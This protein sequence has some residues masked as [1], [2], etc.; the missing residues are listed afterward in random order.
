MK[1]FTNSL[2]FFLV[3]LL[4]ISCSNDD[5]RNNVSTD[6]EEI[7]E[8]VDIPSINLIA[9]YPFNGNVNDESSNENNGTNF[10]ASLTTDRFGNENAAFQ[11]DG[12]DDY[13]EIIPVSDVTAIGDFTFSVWTYLESWENQMGF[14]ELDRQ[15][16]FNGH[17]HSSSVTSDFFRPGFNVEFGY[18]NLQEE[19]LQNS[20]VYTLEDLP[21]NY[22]LTYK[23]LPLSGKWR[24]I[25]W[26]R[27]GTQDFSYIDGE[28]FEQTYP[29]KINKSTKLNMQHS[30]YIGTF[31]GNNTNYNDFNYNFHGKID[32]IRFYSN[33]LE[34]NQIMAIFR[35]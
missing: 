3:I 21:N 32:D 22:L 30:W 15:Y 25:I 26:G 33:A 9:Y 11:F 1:N 6:D 8:D 29:S 4:A 2:S 17:A 14:K 16:V 27:K 13:I 24:H 7:F 12:V 31:S 23:N 20:F 18:T 5:E 35:E 34:E 19:N 10:G 28:Y